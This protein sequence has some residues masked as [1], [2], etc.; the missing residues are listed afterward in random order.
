MQRQTNNQLLSQLLSILAGPISTRLPQSK[1]KPRYPTSIR[2]RQS[3]NTSQSRLANRRYTPSWHFLRCC[4][5]AS[6]SRLRALRPSCLRCLL[7]TP[8][9]PRANI[10]VYNNKPPAAV[11]RLRLR[12]SSTWPQNLISILPTKPAWLPFRKPPGSADQQPV[13]EQPRPSIGPI[14]KFLSQAYAPYYCQAAHRW[15]TC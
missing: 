11:P 3:T 15:E 14:S 8:F 9:R 4:S 2:P 5:C 7:F 6:D 12:R 10:R 1:P 13:A